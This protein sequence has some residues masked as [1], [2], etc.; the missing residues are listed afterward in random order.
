[1][2]SAILNASGG[3]LILSSLAELP[4]RVQARLARL[5]R[6]GEA[7]VG[8]GRRPQVIA[9]RT[10]AIMEPT[11]D[12]AVAEGRLRQDLFARISEVRVDVPPLRRRREDLPQLAAHLLHV[13]CEA[14][15]TA[16]K[17]FSRSA[18]RLLMAL[19]WPGNVAELAAMVHGVVSFAS[20]PVVQ[21]EHLLDRANLEGMGTRF[22][23]G[24]TLREAKARFERECIAAVILRHRGRMGEA[25]RALGI[26]RTNLYR[27]VRQLKVA[28]TTG[29][30]RR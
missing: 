19:P 15:G 9:L 11:L 16:P 4:D 18:L 25:A 21:I 30:G 22:E 1:M 7:V 14:Q 5:L 10:V 8:G 26:Q 24:T 12:G 29:W 17:V 13:A 27:K 23:A 2:D 28:E 3:T 6:D 20:G